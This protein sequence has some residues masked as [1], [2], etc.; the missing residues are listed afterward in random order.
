MKVRREDRNGWIGSIVFHSVIALMLFLW[1][2]DVSVSEPE[3]IEV[4]WG[5]VTNVP[6]ASIARLSMASADAPRLSSN[7]A[8]TTQRDLPER[9]IDLPDEILRIPAAKKIDVRDSSPSERVRLAGRSETSRERGMGSGLG[10]KEKFVTPGVGPL[11]GDVADPRV[12]GALS[13]GIGDAVSVSMQWSDG[14]TRKKISGELPEYPSGVN[15]EAQIKIEAV[16]LPDGSVKSLKPAQKGNT[17]LEEAAMKKVR[18][19]MFEALKRSS[20]QVDQTCVITF[21]FRLQ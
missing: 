18:L 1:E 20:P 8:E 10:E 17:R 4:T 6:T 2:V 7:V 12:T 21:N 9:S 15:V 5:A 19:W 16:V 3:F 14:G 13:G 11:A